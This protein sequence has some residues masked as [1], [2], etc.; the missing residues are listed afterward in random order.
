[1]R[2]TSY[3]VVLPLGLL[4]IGLLDCG[5]SSPTPQ[6]T[7]N[8]V[9][10]AMCQRMSDCGQLG[11]TSVADCTKS[12]QANNCSSTAIS[13]AC[14]AGSTF[15]PSEAQKCI[16]EQRSQSCTDL[17]SGVEPDA[18]TQ[19]CTTG[20]GGGGAGGGSGGT[21]GGGTGGTSSPG[22]LGAWDACQQTMVIMCQKTSTCLGSAGLSDLG[23]TSVSSCTT[24]MQA[25]GCV[26]VTQSSCAD[27][28]VYHA[29]QAQTCLG[30]LPSISCT[31][32]SNGTFPSACD[33]MCQ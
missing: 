6:D 20:G 12:M 18:C 29:D 32:F 28:E 23:Y 22:T 3:I 15:Q 24:D 8:Q 14:P 13:L 9:M 2:R 17:G 26:D 30:S 25:R 10:A 33:L 4:A 11:T 19:V 31:D 21:G 5:G 16:D 7:C 1:M 27:G